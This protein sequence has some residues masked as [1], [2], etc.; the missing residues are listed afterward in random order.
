MTVD[1]LKP[2]CG[3]G[4]DAAQKRT[5]ARELPGPKCGKDKIKFQAVSLSRTIKKKTKDR[6]KRKG[7][8]L[9]KQLLCDDE[10]TR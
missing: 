6:N 3:G 2:L 1:R 4:L 8:T 7:L 9:I 5:L 10:L